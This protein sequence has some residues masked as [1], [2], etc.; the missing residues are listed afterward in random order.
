MALFFLLFFY[1]CTEESE[2]E[3][4]V[5]M[6]ILYNFN[7]SDEKC[8]VINGK[9]GIKNVSPIKI[10]ND[11]DRFMTDRSYLSVKDRKIFMSMPWPFEDIEEPLTNINK[12]TEEISFAG[13]ENI[14]ELKFSASR[15]DENISLL[16]I[17]ATVCYEMP[18]FI[19]ENVY[20]SCIKD[21][22]KSLRK[23]Y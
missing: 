23:N 8:T 12:K 3:R 9:G 15:I 4:I 1:A 16:N 2:K 20:A 18:T 22:I 10:I 6:E 21:I 13:T 7:K 11:M 17:N 19:K 14:P 5:K